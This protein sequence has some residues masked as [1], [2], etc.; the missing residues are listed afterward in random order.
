[1]NAAPEGFWLIY[2]GDCPV[3][4][5]T[6]HA[7]SIRKQYGSMTLVDARTAPD[8]PVCRKASAAGLDLDEGMVIF[9]DGGVYHGAGAIS[10]L[11]TFGDPGNLL[12]KMSRA[13]NRSARFS[14]FAYGLLRGLRNV[15]LRLR[16]IGRIDNLH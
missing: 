15:L 7:I 16:G 13:V 2:D 10:F 12:T 4:R 6:A 3:C 9:A 5:S 1:M 11:A 14:A 8:H